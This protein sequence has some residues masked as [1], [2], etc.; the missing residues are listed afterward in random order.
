MSFEKL[1]IGLYEPVQAHKAISGLWPIVKPWIISEHRLHLE[2][3]QQKRNDRQNRA[4][5]ASIT[6]ISKQLE[7]A[8]RKRDVTTWK[9]LL[10]AAF[11][12]ARGEHLE[13]LPALDGHGVD[14]V[15]ERTSDLTVAECSEFQEYVY[16]WGSSHG[17]KFS[18]PE[19]K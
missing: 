10:M 16:A 6:D 9:R 3:R 4:L 17:V 7:W 12:R 18:A 13:I 15:F 8:G 1:V 11:L 14:I 5:H 2:V 19:P